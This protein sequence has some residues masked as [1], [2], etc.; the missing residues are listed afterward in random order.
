MIYIYSCEI[1]GREFDEI[2]SYE[3]RYEVFC[4][5]QR[6]VKHLADTVHCADDLMYQF[7]SESFGA[8]PVQIYSRRQY[9]KL[10]KENNL[11]QVT[12]ED[13]KGIKTNRKSDYTKV[14]N[15]IMERCQRDGVAQHVK[16]FM[17]KLIPTKRG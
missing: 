8:R 11:V 9:Q 6:A 16:P 13:R 15:R 14:V 10:C 5:G 2:R 4:C 7:V 1:C 17:K 12:K 3:K